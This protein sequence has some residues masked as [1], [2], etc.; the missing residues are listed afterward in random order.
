MKVHMNI[1]SRPSA[2]FSKYASN[3]NKAPVTKDEY[4]ENLQTGVDDIDNT[5]NI[6]MILMQKGEEN[7]AVR[8]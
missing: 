5:R 1:I 4:Y 6:I 7:E 3:D 2:I 8:L